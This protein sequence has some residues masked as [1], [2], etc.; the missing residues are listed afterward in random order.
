MTTM[1]EAMTEPVHGSESDSE[2]QS[3][4]H[5]LLGDVRTRIIASYV[6][7][8]ALAGISTVLIVRQVLLERVDDRVES[9]LA[10]E[11]GEFRR[12]AGG[13]D[14]ATSEPFG[15]DVERIFQVFLQRNVP[16]E[17]EQL[18]TIPRQG[19]PDFLA[20]ATAQPGLPRELIEGWREIRSVDR[21][22]IE[23]QAGTLRYLAIPVL[24]GDDL[25]GSFAVTSLLAGEQEEV[26]EAIR[27]V[28]TVAAVILLIGT[29]AAFLLVGRVVAP[30]REL[31]D[32]A[33]S[34]T[35]SDMTQRIAVRGNDELA[36]LGRTFNLML[37]RLEL[38]FA[39]QRGFI[40][41][42]GHE[43][44]TPIAIVRGHLELLAEEDQG[45]D[46][47]REEAFEMLAGELDRMTRFVN[48]M[49]LLAKAERP[50]FLQLETV[51]LGELC[52]EVLLKARALGE[53]DWSI[54]SSANATIVADRQRLT[55]ALINLL[56]NSVSSTMQ[57]ESI[58]IG[59]RIE[60]S[61]ALIWVRDE[62]RGIDPA[63][64]DT[65]L[66]PFRRGRGARYE[67]SG[68][69]LPIV[70]AIAGAHGGSLSIDSEL[71]RGTTVD[72]EDS[73]RGTEQTPESEE[74][75]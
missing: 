61:Q 9:N 52:D 70:A 7:L 41:D 63:E 46:P 67:G 22:E 16:S 27:I 45:G 56:G 28:G 48:D 14:P 11:V 23:T 31:R 13:I 66:E 62:G 59:S 30:L 25:L 17:G 57:G 39:S 71:D 51:R 65:V 24:R 37:D 26:E 54:E 43:L 21:G 60:G 29:A 15:A 33:R 44:R 49:L 34:V 1:G 58:A 40:R 38:A 74:E 18:I 5:R 3:L 19:R 32:A 4:R 8:L 10:Q 73:G 12:L 75:R 50:D 64:R 55:Q 20:A 42:A 53:R 72:L 2:P 47:S 35:G 36:E 6:V 68:L 69:G